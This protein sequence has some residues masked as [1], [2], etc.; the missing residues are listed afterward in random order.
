MI[1]ASM[2]NGRTDSYSVS[3]PDPGELL[4]RC[5]DQ[6]VGFDHRSRSLRHTDVPYSN[7]HAEHHPE[8][9]PPQPQMSGVVAQCCH[10]EDSPPVAPLVVRSSPWDELPDGI[11]VDIL[12]VGD[13]VVDSG[14]DVHHSEGM[15]E[16][17]VRCAW[18]DEVAE[19]QL[20]CN[21]GVQSL[22]RARIDKF[23]FF[24]IP[25]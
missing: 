12:Q 18:V 15:L 8:G 2:A 20:L 21:R 10:S 19:R 24:R 22:K 16:S 5:L 7:V 4:S 6:I 14:R 1:C 17:T 9:R 23:T 25:A 3:S 11:V 13:D